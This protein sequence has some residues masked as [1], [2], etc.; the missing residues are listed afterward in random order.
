M[1][2]NKKKKD[3]HSNLSISEN[4]KKERTFDL[5]GRFNKV[6]NVVVVMS[7]CATEGGSCCL[8]SDCPI[9]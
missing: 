7:I 4:V 5:C 6:L 3:N 8:L 2:K 1:K 9:V